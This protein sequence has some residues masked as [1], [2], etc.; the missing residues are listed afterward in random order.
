MREF[1][2]K[3]W[4]PKNKDWINEA[5][6]EIGQS[7]NFLHLYCKEFIPIQFTGLLDKNG[8]EI[9]EGDIIKYNIN[10]QEINEI[11]TDIVTY[12]EFRCGFY[13]FTLINYCEDNYYS[14]ELVNIEIIGNI[15]E[16][17]EL[18]NK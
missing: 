17:P 9:Y 18:L 2:F 6:I 5:L 12:L 14:T 3:F 1:K 13:P 4:S 10:T 16:N 8:K 11:A 7:G 15:Y